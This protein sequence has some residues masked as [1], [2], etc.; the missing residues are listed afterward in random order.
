MTDLCGWCHAEM[1]GY[2]WGE[3]G[4]ALAGQR[5]HLKC[6][7]KMTTAL[8]KEGWRFVGAEKK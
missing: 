6:F 1:E 2:G 3:D 7:K 4:V 8:K 5:Y